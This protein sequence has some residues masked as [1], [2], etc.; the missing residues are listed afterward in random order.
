MGTGTSW[1]AVEG[2]TL[3]QLARELGLAPVTDRSAH[4]DESS[5]RVAMLPN[6]WALLVRPMEG[7]G[8]VA[9]RELLKKLSS[10]RG[11]VGCDEESHVMYSAS[12]EWR[13]GSEV[14][15]EIHSS[16]QAPDHLDT[17]GE[18]PPEGA[19]VKAAW[20]AKHAEAVRA[21]EGVDYVYEVPL[22]LA[23]LVVG[24]R[25]ESEDDDE[26]ELVTLVAA[27]PKPWWR[28]W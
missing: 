18:L 17:R 20:I 1:I 14:W 3:E 28:F 7:D 26:L 24:Y 10:G 16:A 6:G 27:S 15:A 19:A 11:V 23:K 21:G 25:L 22:E 2:T 12:S 8:V 5:F 9:E 13:D 4:R